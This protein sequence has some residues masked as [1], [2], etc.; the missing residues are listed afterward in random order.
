MP[1][2][3]VAGVVLR[4]SFLNP[5]QM[6]YRF[7]GLLA[8][9]LLSTAAQAQLITNP[10][11][12]VAARDTLWHEAEQLKRGAAQVALP[13]TTNARVHSRKRVVVVGV[14][15]PALIP[16]GA[17]SPGQPAPVPPVVKWRHITRYRRNGRVQ[18]SYRL[19]VNGNDVLRERRLNGTV[20]WLHIPAAYSQ[21]AGTPMHHRG[22]YLR[23]GYV[24]LDNEAFVLPQPLQ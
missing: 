10:A 24:R 8:G 11:R 17:R 16:G 19:S 7:G 4:G 23:S 18:E 9:L 20:I 2:V 6:L 13:F 14:V 3:L 22:L 21:V 12:A 15:D 5:F 1:D